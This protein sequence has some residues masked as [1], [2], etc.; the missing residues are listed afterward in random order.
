[1]RT[2]KEQASYDHIENLCIE[3]H[4]NHLGKILKTS[5]VIG[6]IENDSVEIY[7]NPPARVRVLGMQQRDMLNWTCNEWCDPNWDIDLVEPHQ[8]L[9]NCSSIWVDGISRSIDGEVQHPS[10]WVIDENQELPP[11]QT[12]PKNPEE[13]IKLQPAYTHDT[14]VFCPH[15]CQEIIVTTTISIDEEK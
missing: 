12:P 2:T 5:L 9:K 11:P 4:E 8:Q 6:Y 3:D 10:V 14:R 1:M 7:C 15:C 13:N